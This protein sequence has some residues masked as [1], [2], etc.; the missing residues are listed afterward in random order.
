MKKF[1]NVDVIAFMEKV[2]AINTERFQNDL[3]GDIVHLRAA[4]SS[5][6]PLSKKWIWLS[7]KSGTY[8][9]RESD[10]FTKDNFANTTI[11]YYKRN[12]NPDRLLLFFI[13]LTDSKGSRRN[14][15]GNIFVY[16]YLAF[17][18]R[19]EDMEVEEPQRLMVYEWGVSREKR[20]KKVSRKAHPVLGKFL[21]SDEIPGADEPLK[22][23]LAQEAA[24]RKAAYPGSVDRYLSRLAKR[25]GKTLSELQL[26]G[27]DLLE[28]GLAYV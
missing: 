6:D 16:D 10:T 3:E 18:E 2:V 13:D 27:S 15:I 21:Y 9:F 1:E 4:M 7:R 22:K 20:D 19:L 11:K 23:V 12:A 28:G 8:V 24:Y 14:V 25:R 17:C 26:P 5:P